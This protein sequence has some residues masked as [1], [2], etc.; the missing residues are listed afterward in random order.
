MLKYIGR[1]EWGSY[2]LTPA[3]S[4]PGSGQC[5][6]FLTFSS[7]K[8]DHDRKERKK[9]ISSHFY[10]YCAGKTGTGFPSLHSFIVDMP[11]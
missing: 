3:S 4:T 9:N 10:R 1:D 7:P 6:D 5:S 11:I 8:F 2:K